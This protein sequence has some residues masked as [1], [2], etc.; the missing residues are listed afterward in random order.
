MCRLFCISSLISDNVT[1]DTVRALKA[2]R[3]AGL[4]RT[5]YL[6]CE[7]AFKLCEIC[8]SADAEIAMVF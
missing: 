2:Q 5:R 8:I 4:I 7:A 6:G 3:A 1:I